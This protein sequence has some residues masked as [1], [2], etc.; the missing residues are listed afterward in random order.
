MQRPYHII[1]IVSIIMLA[2]FISCNPVSKYIYTDE[3]L[4]WEEDIARFDSLNRT[5]HAD[6]NTLLVTGSSSVR[7]W[8]SIHTDM[9]PYRVIQRGYGGAKLT[10][11]NYYAERV[12]GPY[13]YRAILIFVAN[14]ISGR[15]QDRTPREVLLLYK[16]LIKK[17][18]QERPD[19]PVFWIEITPTPSRWHAID[20]I[21]KANSL[22]EAY[23]GR[24]TNLYFIHTADTYLNQSG[25]PDSTFFRDDMLHL[26]RQ[27]YLLW[28]REIKTS[29]HEA[30]IDPR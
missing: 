5:E 1:A 12:M 3:V 24:D 22:I 10:D 20:Q 30:G 6:E 17:I 25:M 4:G 16:T 13:P 21:R 19:T 29:L 18:R 14:D 2:L 8:D 28:A 7:L 11:Y 26:N 9:L 27:G 23:C 15:E